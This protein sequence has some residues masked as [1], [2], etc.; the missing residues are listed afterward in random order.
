MAQQASK[1]RGVA[2]GANSSNG[3]TVKPLTLAHPAK[4]AGKAPPKRYAASICPGPQQ[5][6]PAHCVSAVQALENSLGMPVWLLIQD[7]NGE[8]GQMDERVRR[9]F[10]SSKDKLPS[11]KPVALLIDSPGG[12]AK[13][14][15]QIA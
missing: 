2:T 4:G 12:Y 13:T 14:A 3:R 1:K 8:F 6:L 5:E 7:G 9:V 15:Y 11:G 10:F